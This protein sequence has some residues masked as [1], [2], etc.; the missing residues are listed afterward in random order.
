MISFLLFIC[1]IF[2]I[3]R[4]Y[5][6]LDAML[7]MIDDLTFSTTFE[8]GKV[9]P[10]Y[11][12]PLHLPSVLAEVVNAVNTI[13]QKAGVGVAIKLHCDG[14]G[15]D[16][17]EVI[18]DPFFP[19]VLYS[20]LRNAVKY[21]PTDG[22][23]D[24]TVTYSPTPL[25]SILSANFN[26]DHPAPQHAVPKLPSIEGR[27]PS[28]A[29]PRVMRSRSQSFNSK[30]SINTVPDKPQNFLPSK[31][32]FT[33]HFCNKTEVPFDELRVRNFFR[34]YYHPIVKTESTKAAEDSFGLKMDSDV[35][36]EKFLKSVAEKNKF[37]DLKIC[38]GLGLGL[39][40]AYNMISLM[41]SCEIFLDVLLILSLITLRFNCPNF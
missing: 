26:K 17:E 1:F 40:T 35:A 3:Y 22:V 37:K 20:L 36:R 24:V 8:A 10:G 9:S 4:H 16:V 15:P 30:Q 29:S 23:V 19:R 39:Y 2:I 31:G 32:T 21:S 33:F 13:E 5:F 11:P 7:G 38:Q 12:V 25:Y 27:K 34:S 6:C 18:A 41:V 28:F 14:V